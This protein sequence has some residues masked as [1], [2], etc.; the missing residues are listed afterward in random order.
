MQVADRANQNGDQQKDS[1]A[2]TGQVVQE[3]MTSTVVEICL[4][5]ALL[6]AMGN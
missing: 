2:K 6:M 5:A 3:D 4:E 1:D